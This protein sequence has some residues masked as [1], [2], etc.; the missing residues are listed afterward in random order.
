MFIVL[1]SVS[2]QV[3]LLINSTCYYAPLTGDTSSFVTTVDLGWNGDSTL[4][5]ADFVLKLSSGIWLDQATISDTNFDNGTLFYTADS[6]SFVWD[7]PDSFNTVGPLAPL[8]DLVLQTNLNIVD[9]ISITSNS[10]TNYDGLVVPVYY[11]SGYFFPTPELVR[12]P[13]DTLVCEGNPAYFSIEANGFGA[14]LAYQWEFSNDSLISWTDVP[15]MAPY[16]G[17]NDDTLDIQPVDTNQH[18]LIFHCVVDNSICALVVSDSAKLSVISNITLQPLDQT[19]FLSDTAVFRTASQSSTPQYLWEASIDNG[20]NWSS[21]L[22]FPPVTT[23]MLTL[24]NPPLSWTGYRFRC[25]VEGDCQPPDTTREALLTIINDNSTEEISSAQATLIPNPMNDRTEFT[26][27]FSD[28]YELSIYD[29]TGR[30]V[31]ELK[32]LRGATIIERGN[33]QKGTYILVAEQVVKKYRT[34]LLL[35]IE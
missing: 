26:P 6:L 10:F 14:S 5:H 31:T 12:Q 28:A 19:I 22:L 13:V 27:Q 25:I 34:E 17:T 33:L 3:A 20:V 8:L 9:S 2:A 15:N 23:A 4:I 18:H 21:S 35:I 16:T 11:T 29:L 30:A 24:I 7:T 32:D 1:Q